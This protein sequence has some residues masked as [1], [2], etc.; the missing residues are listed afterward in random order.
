MNVL[1]VY[2]NVTRQE[3]IPL[4]IAHLSSAIRAHGHA[5]CLMDYTWGGSVRDCLETI[6]NK[7]PDC[8]AFSIFSGAFGFSVLLSTEIKRHFTIP[9][10]AGGPHPTV[11]ADQTI[12]A[13][14]FDMV[15]VGEGEEAFVEVL[16]NIAIGNPVDGVAGIWSKRGGSVIRNAVRPLTEDLDCLPF[17]DR[18][19]FDFMTYLRVRGGTADI[20]SGRGCPYECTYCINPFVQ[21]LY[22]GKGRYVRKR[23]VPNVIAEIKELTEAYP[24]R[25]LDFHDDVFAGNVEWLG[26]FSAAYAGAVR[27]PFI[28]SA[29]PEMIDPRTVGLLKAAGCVSVA[30]G[31]ES[32]D[33]EVRRN[34]LNRR[35]SDDRIIEAFRLVRESGIATYSYNIVGL[36]YE[37][38]DKIKK[39][40]E[41][42]RRAR[43]SAL[44]VTVFQPY[45]G[46][47]LETLSREKGWLAEGRQLPLSHK[48][49]SILSYPHLSK[50]SIE[51]ARA[52]FRF[53]VL[54]NRNLHRA[55]L[56]L[57][58]DLAQ[59]WYAKIRSCI[60]LW[61]RR[62]LFGV[63][64]L[65]RHH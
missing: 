13:G 3:Y 30:I 38:N 64:E 25:C 29:R 45:P 48:L 49:Y 47:K 26:D 2:P 11:A 40:I 20:M 63:E 16:D 54:K 15:C 23:S 18:G 8:V 44:Q 21:E 58:F 31:I 19:L 43:P 42:N 39:T 35:L 65:L 17:P 60:P 51:N 59:P 36:P 41:L 6:R 12:A 62:A 1:F 9:V 61:I 34:V 37:T 27:L 28:C 33:E 55:F 7:K 53:N 24:V 57:L 5:S 52:F 46:T 4:G 32:G 10:I 56:Y 50:R 14:V 22:K